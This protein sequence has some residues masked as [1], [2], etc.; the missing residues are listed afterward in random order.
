MNRN[1]LI[2]VI[3]A[4]VV[5]IAAVALAMSG[6]GGDEPSE[7][8]KCSVRLDVGQGDGTYVRYADAQGTTVSDLL[9]STLGDDI[10][11]RSN[12][13]VASYKGVSNTGD[14]SWVVLRWM[15]LDGWKAVQG[16]QQLIEGSSYVL[17]FAERVEGKD[18]EYK[19]PEYSIS[20]EVYFFVQIPSMSEIEKI[21]KSGTSRPDDKSEGKKMTASERFDVMMGWFE[22]AGLDTESME[23][24]FWI[25]GEGT[26][27]NEALADAVAKCLY[28]SSEVTVTE[29]GGIIEYKLDGEVVHACLS[30]DKMYGWFVGFFGWA[31]TQLENGDWTYWS[32]FTYNP[33]AKTLD[34]T[35]QWTY[36]T[37]SLGQYD[38]SVYKYYALVLQTTSEKQADDGVEM[39]MPT[40]SEIP[41]GL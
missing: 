19:A 13:N 35:R 31:D 15:S 39:V 5:G 10:T 34:D 29:G 22:K 28:P 1:I 7:S 30:N 41:E 40:P 24:G 32:Q 8:Q 2:A 37:L 23:D 12:G 18:I 33:N 27:A 38:M 16:T 3:I 4:A 20:S 9:T 14:H 25:K 21:A 26:T 6:G 36:N 11:L 17:D